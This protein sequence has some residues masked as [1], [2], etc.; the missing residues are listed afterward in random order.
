MSHGG[1]DLIAIKTP[2][3]FSMLPLLSLGE[4]E[5]KSKVFVDVVR[6]FVFKLSKINFVDDLTQS[7]C[8]SDPKTEP[9]TLPKIDVF[10]YVENLDFVR[11]SNGF[12]W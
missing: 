6:V 9:Q 7:W 11:P 1:F 12:S 3:P 2:R 10:K 5:L 4:W 8:Q